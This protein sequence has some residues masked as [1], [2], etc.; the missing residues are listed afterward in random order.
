MVQ[1]TREILQEVKEEALGFSRAGVEQ[2]W[3]MA[4]VKAEEEVG[5]ADLRN[6]GGHHGLCSEWNSEQERKTNWW[7]GRSQSWI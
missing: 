1:F 5:Q 2:A 7:E 6:L 3:G 4:S